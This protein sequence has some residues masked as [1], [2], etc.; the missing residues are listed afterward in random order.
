M[1]LQSDIRTFYELQPVLPAGQWWQICVLIVAAIALLI[2]AW[3]IYRKDSVDL[4]RPA[5][6]LLTSL[7]W[8]T[9]GGIFLFVLNPGQRSETRIVKPSRLSILM[10]NSLS[11]GLLDPVSEN[12]VDRGLR[13]QQLIDWLAGPLVE[14]FRGE[15]EVS[16]YSFG[17]SDQPKLIESF[18]KNFGSENR[19]IDLSA[20]E[21]TAFL[22]SQWIVW[23]G[24]LVSLLALVFTVFG[25]TR[26]K[27]IKPTTSTTTTTK[28]ELKPQAEIKA[29]PSRFESWWF[30]GGVLLLLIGLTLLAIGDLWL[31]KIQL[32]QSLGLQSAETSQTNLTS[33][34]A[35]SDAENER[36]NNPSPEPADVAW[37]AELQPQGT[38]TRIGSAIQYIVNKEQ[39]GPI[40]GIVLFTDGQSNSGIS[41]DRAIAAATNAGIPIF[42][43]GVGSTERPQNVLIAD[44]QAPERVLPGDRFQVKALV[45]A[46]GLEGRTAR[47]Q[48]ISV[49]EKE[50]EAEIVEE[51]TNIRL[52]GDGQPAGVEFAV[53]RTELGKRRYE[54]RV[55]SFEEDLD[56]RDN[57]RAAI[58]EIIEQQTNVLLMAGGPTREFRFL[59]NQMYRDKDIHLDVWLQSAEP[60]ADQESDVLLEAFPDTL[61]EV[62]KYDCILAIDPDWRLM[63]ADQ[64]KMLERWVA[65]QAGGLIVI[66]GP[67]NTPRWT[68]QPRGDDAIDIIRKLY[69]VSFYSQ[70]SSVLKLGRFGG[71]TAFPLDF[72]RQ[73]R[74]AEYL[75]IGDSAGESQETW[76][77]FEGVFGYYAVNDAK[78]GAEILANFADP[79]TA[80]DDQLPIYLASQFYGAGRVFFQA[81]GEMWR[82]RR[83]DVNYFEQYYTKLIRWASQGRLSRDSTQGLL[84]TDRERCWMGD[85]IAV[86]AILKN[87]QDQPLDYPQVEA[88]LITPSKETQSIL[89][90]SNPDAASPGSF[91]GNFLAAEEGE[92]RINL[93]IP[94]NPNLEVLSTTVTAAIA[95]LEKEK[96]QRNDAVLSK[97]AKNTGGTYF[98]SPNQFNVQPDN[99]VSVAQ[100][101]PPQDQETI[102]AGSFDRIFKRK[103]MMWLLGI[104]AACLATEWILRRLQKLA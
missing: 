42:T 58:V 33:P 81:S 77:K 70:G 63:N 102:I 36:E 30:S 21:E 46:F 74:S 44:L 11:M 93:P 92:Y 95:D 59:R 38:S 62:Y 32:A 25:L 78:S 94:E 83:L 37:A 104:F 54:I 100:L 49:D 75:W 14:K 20:E 82:V 4:K 15:H 29:P 6:F 23:S 57:K 86:Q 18:S 41:V 22:Q 68:R 48:L 7:R 12:S 9:I 35:D 90:R 19:A 39:G 76:A 53:Q 10:D 97:I 31:P 61:E 27:P 5:A 43:V 98:Q 71:S 40:A 1:I 65:E 99:P 45:K 52:L 101:I 2:F 103:F 47:V 55:E 26:R 28:S 67:V 79:E 56:A 89:L 84:L 24:A 88:V 13:S 91:S 69:P 3:I 8:L 34:A 96:P 64:S 87:A 50:T 17:D 51:E 85:T 16:V 60:G 73:G 72:S 80:V 66:A